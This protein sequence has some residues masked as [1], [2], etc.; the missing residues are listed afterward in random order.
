MKEEFISSEET[1]SYV[2]KP[3]EFDD[4][5]ERKRLRRYI[6]VLVAIENVD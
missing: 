1:N 3:G 2:K 4:W 6:T 5:K